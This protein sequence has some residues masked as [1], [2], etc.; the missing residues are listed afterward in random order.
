MAALNQ[1]VLLHVFSYLTAPRDLVRAGMAN[2]EWH[3]LSEAESLWKDLY[4]RNASSDSATRSK[5]DDEVKTSPQP[6]GPSNN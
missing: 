3:Q 5:N 4:F 1:D 2:K 6:L